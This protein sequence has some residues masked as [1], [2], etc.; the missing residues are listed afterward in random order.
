FAEFSRFADPDVRQRIPDPNAL[1][2]FENS[3]PDLNPAS[4]PRQ[5]EWL[6]FYRELLQLRHERIVPGLA[7]ARS[8]GAKV[9]GD[10]AV[11]ARWRLGNGQMLRITLNIA[12]SDLHIGAP[13]LAAE[14]LYSL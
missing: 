11:D 7:A 1:S 13:A 12:A 2:T 6:A 8:L 9:L 4:R 5:R 14:R 10:G 3:R